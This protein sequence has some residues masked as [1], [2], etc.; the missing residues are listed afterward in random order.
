[1]ISNTD[2]R[3]RFFGSWRRHIKEK[4]K[5]L[6]TSIMK[7]LFKAPD[8]HFSTTLKVLVSFGVDP[9]NGNIVKILEYKH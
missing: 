9:Y 5:K 2:I 6:S 8:E 1:M 7:C 4:D 3:P